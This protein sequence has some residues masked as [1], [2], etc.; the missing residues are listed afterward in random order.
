MEA[1][2]S[3]PNKLQ[4]K[5]QKKQKIHKN[6][7]IQ[8]NQQTLHREPWGKACQSPGEYRSIN[9]CVSTEYH[10]SVVLQLKQRSRGRHHAEVHTNKKTTTQKKKQQQQQNETIPSLTA[11]IGVVSRHQVR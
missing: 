3:S 8:T 2:C 10:K 7:R 4:G 5:K 9:V 6:K 11:S 1:I